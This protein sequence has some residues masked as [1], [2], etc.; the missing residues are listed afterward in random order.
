MFSSHI[1]Y[2]NLVAFI[3]AWWLNFIKQRGEAKQVREIYSVA[4]LV[5]IFIFLLLCSAFS[6]IS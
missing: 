1:Y 3:S 4:A 6:G 2:E 5:P